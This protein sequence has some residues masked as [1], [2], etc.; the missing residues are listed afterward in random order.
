MADRKFVRPGHWGD[1][2]RKVQTMQTMQEIGEE[3]E[4]G[5]AAGTKV[6]TGSGADPKFWQDLGKDQE[7]VQ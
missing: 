4:I 5:A 2:G 7:K 3:E 6:M 1:P